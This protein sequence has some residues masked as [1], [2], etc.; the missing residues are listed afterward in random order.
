MLPCRKGVHTFGRSQV[1]ARIK[2]RSHRS[3][4]NQRLFHPV[5]QCVKLWQERPFNCVTSRYQLVSQGTLMKSPCKPI[6]HYA[7]AHGFRAREPKNLL[8]H[9]GGAVGWR[10][11]AL[12]VSP[13]RPARHFHLSRPERR[14]S[15][16]AS[17][18]PTL[19]LMLDTAPVKLL[20]HC[21]IQNWMHVAG[22]D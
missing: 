14:L 11:S 17:T 6:W 18:A 2:C 5:T 1:S 13:S 9:P 16:I 3:M 7:W 8:T 4:L 21:C 20:C 19:R 12:Q 10:R 22:C 15:P